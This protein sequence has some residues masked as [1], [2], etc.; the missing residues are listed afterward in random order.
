KMNNLEKKEKEIKTTSQ[1]YHRIILLFLRFS[2]WIV[3]PVILALIIGNTIDGRYDSEPWATLTAIGVAFIFSMIGIVKEIK[4]Y[5]KM[6][7]KE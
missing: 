7:D 3:G 2:G 6:V 4:E 5:K 1:E